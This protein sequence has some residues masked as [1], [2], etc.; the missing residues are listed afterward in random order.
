MVCLNFGS[1]LIPDYRWDEEWENSTIFDPFSDLVYDAFTAYGSCRSRSQFLCDMHTSFT[2][3]INPDSL[4][5]LPC[6]ASY[7]YCFTSNISNETFYPEKEW[8]LTDYAPLHAP[9]RLSFAYKVNISLPVVFENR[10]LY[11]VNLQ[12][13]FIDGPDTSLFLIVGDSSESHLLIGGRRTLSIRFQANSAKT[14]KVAYLHVPYTDVD[15][16]GDTIVRLASADAA[17]PLLSFSALLLSLL[18]LACL[19]L[20]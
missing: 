4:L 3:H 18:S 16:K 1:G 10:G 12:S 11:P 14:N 19:A 8:A 15:G 5:S 6:P 17:L 13:P 7:S 20:I 9:S 2:L